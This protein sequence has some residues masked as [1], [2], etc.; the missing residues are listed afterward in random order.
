M[1][2][3]FIHQSFPVIDSLSLS[4]SRC[5]SLLLTES[6]FLPKNL[7]RSLISLAVPLTISSPL[8]P[9]PHSTLSPAPFVLPSSLS[10]YLSKWQGGILFPLLLLSP[11]LLPLFP[12]LRLFLLSASLLVWTRR[13]TLLPL[14]FSLSE[15]ACG[16]LSDAP[17]LSSAALHVFALLP[18][19]ISLSPLISCSAASRV[20]CSSVTRGYHLPF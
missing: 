14:S 7:S 15:Q 13:S 2:P 11:H 3:S 4:L 9:S 16:F 6:Q 18:P 10:L 8:P 12:S 20:V 5:L 19:S 1:L 17:L